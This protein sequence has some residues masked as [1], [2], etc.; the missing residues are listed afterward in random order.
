M[1]IDTEA[2]PKTRAP[3]GAKCCKRRSAQH[4]APLER[5]TSMEPTDYKHFAK[6]FVPT[7]LMENGDSEKARSVFLRKTIN[8]ASHRTVS[9]VA[10]TVSLRLR[11]AS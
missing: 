4:S 9:G 10:Q 11:S 7:G 3:T 6:H 2:N 1:F 8:R 5:G